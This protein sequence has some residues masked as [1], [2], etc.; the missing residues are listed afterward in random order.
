MNT[1]NRPTQ[2]RYP[3]HWLESE[4]AGVDLLKQRPRAV[5]WAQHLTNPTTPKRP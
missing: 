3:D 1:A 5:Q 4:V 2:E